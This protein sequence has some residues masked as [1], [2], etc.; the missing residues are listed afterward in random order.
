MYT[1]SL[2]SSLREIGEKED[3]KVYSLV[4]LVNFSERDKWFK[5][6]KAIYDHG[7]NKDRLQ[8]FMYSSILFQKIRLPFR[9]SVSFLILLFLQ[10]KYHIFKTSIH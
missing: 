6:H 8:S 5:E 9:S 7:R 10:I 1:H 2:C 4:E 3:Q